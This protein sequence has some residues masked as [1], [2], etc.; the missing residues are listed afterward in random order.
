MLKEIQAKAEK[1]MRKAIEAT[2]KGFNGVRTG[3]A[4]LAL[5]DGVMVEAYGSAVPLNQVGTLA[6]PETRLITVQPWDPSL[7]T[8]IERAI[9]KS[10]L[11]VT[12]GNDGKVIRIAIPSLTEERRKDLVKVVRKIAEEGRVA[13]RNAR[14]EANESLKRQEREK[15]ASEDDVKHGVDMVQDL[16]NR[17]IHEI[18]GLLAK[19]EKEIMEF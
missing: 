12:P 18:D 4:S 5:L 19:K 15:E 13:V 7:L 6:V 17:L 10:D 9:L 2:L 8:A 1:E 3:R 14:R 11:G 16:T